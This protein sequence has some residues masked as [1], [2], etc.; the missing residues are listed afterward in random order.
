MGQAKQK[1]R[2]CPA[3]GSVISPSECGENRASRYGCPESCPH[4]P[5]SSASYARALEIEGALNRKAGERLIWETRDLSSWHSALSESGR[6]GPIVGETLYIQKLYRERDAEGLTFFQRWER[7]RFEGLVNDERVLLRRMANLRLSL[8]ELHRVTDRELC[9]GVDLLDANPRAFWIQ[10]RRLSASALRFDVMLGWAFE[11]PHYVRIHGAVTRVPVVSNLDP[12]EIMRAVI[13]HLGGPTETGEWREWLSNNVA[14]VS[15]SFDAVNAGVRWKMFESLDGTFFKTTYRLH[16]PIEEALRRLRRLSCV[17]VGQ[18]GDQDL[19]GG[20]THA[21]EWFGEAAPIEKEQIPLPPTEGRPRLGRV[22]LATDLVR[23]E[24]SNKPRYHALRA[25]FETQMGR[26]VEFVQEV[27][28]DLAARVRSG[29]KPDLTLVP[30]LLLER[31]P[32]LITQVSMIDPSFA[33]MPRAEAKAEL[34][35]RQYERLIEDPLPSL[36]GLTPRQAANDP[37]VR[38]RLIRLVKFHLHKVDEDNLRSGRS[39]DLNWMVRELK[40]TEIDFEPPPWRPVPEEWLEGIDGGEDEGALDD[41]R[42]P[43]PPLPAG[44]LSEEE[45]GRWIAKSMAEFGD[46]IKLQEAFENAAPALCKCLNTVLPKGSSDV[47]FAFLLSVAAR[48][49][50]MFNPMG[51]APC[52]FDLERF[53]AALRREVKALASHAQEN[54]LEDYADYPSSGR[55]PILTEAL[56]ETILQAVDGPVQDLRIRPESAIFMALVIKTLV[57]ELDRSVRD[58]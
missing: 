58:G 54:R 2:D 32:R 27:A 55:Q 35:R 9:E 22:L 43:R 6:Q 39:D 24:A 17:T 41:D 53:G 38:P 44:S 50:F 14:R 30:P 48:A 36:N 29:T 15:E 4:N 31:A 3:V 19:D 52:K 42:P 26:L 25:Q 5:W 8:F 7:A 45:V 16:G 37:A 28:D 49:W 13:A 47:E 51:H 11:M 57:D 56:T 10:D 18:P 12:L 21:F 34:F 40:L 33:A 1:R 23:I 20:F 46:E